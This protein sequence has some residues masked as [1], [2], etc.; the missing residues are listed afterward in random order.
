MFDFVPGSE[1]IEWDI[2][3]YQCRDDIVKILVRTIRCSN[4]R[5]DNIR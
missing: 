3:A 1:E 2:E 5:F 4:N